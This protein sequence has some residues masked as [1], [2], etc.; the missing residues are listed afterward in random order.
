MRDTATAHR[1]ASRPARLSQGVTLVELIIVIAIS[2]IV[3]T[4][5]AVFIVRP[6]EGYQGQVRR[7]ELVDAAE[8]ALRRMARDIR[9]ALPNS[10]R[11]DGTGRVIEMLNTIDGARYRE[12]PGN[13]GHDHA[14]LQYRLTF[15]ASDTDGFNVVGFFN[16]LPAIPF[17]STAERLAIYNQGVPTADAYTDGDESQPA[18]ASYVITR[19]AVTGFTIQ[20]DGGGINDEHQVVP[21]TGFRFRYRSPNQRVYVVD[22]PVTYI[23]A[24]GP[25]GTITRYWGYEIRQAQPTN[26]AAA[27]L[28]GRPY[29]RLTEPVTACTFSYTPGTNQR[30]GLVTLDITFQ[31]SGEV[32]RL[33]HQVHVDN[34]P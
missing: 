20:L 19:P 32:V 13:I 29:A 9:R 22:T 6:I 27:P 31:D 5:L 21:T 33:L 34:S 4:M 17:A 25:N 8:M 26:P 28:A 1:M 7:A 16:N 15:G 23:C 24:P 12:G 10:V 11:V 3:A 2:G 18:P 30:A 14:P